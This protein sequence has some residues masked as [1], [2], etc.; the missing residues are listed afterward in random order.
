MLRELFSSCATLA[1]ESFTDK[2]ERFT[3]VNSGLTNAV[4]GLVVAVL[5]LAIVLFFGKYLWNR[6]GCKYISI[7]KPVPSVIELL[8]LIVL[9]DL[10]LPSCM[11]MTK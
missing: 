7:L 10:V 8:A 5:V 9:L 6:V 2:S 11:C 3:N 1:K 4:M